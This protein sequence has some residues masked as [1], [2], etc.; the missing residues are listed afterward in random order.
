MAFEDK[1][2]QLETWDPFNLSTVNDIK[3]IGCPISQYLKFQ[4]KNYEG[5]TVFS[6]KKKP[7]RYFTNIVLR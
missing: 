3:T 1:D 2:F 5:K 6:S 4:N 7:T